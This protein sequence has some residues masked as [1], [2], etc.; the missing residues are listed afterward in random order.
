VDSPHQVSKNNISLFIV[1]ND[2]SDDATADISLTSDLTGN[3]AYPGQRVTFLCHVVANREILI[4]WTS[5]QYIG[6]KGADL[7]LLSTSEDG[8]TMR[9]RQ[10]RDTVATLLH[11]TRSNE[12]VTVTVEA[13][14][15]LTASA[16]YRN[17]HVS[18]RANGG[19]PRRVTFFTSLLPPR[20]PGNTGMLI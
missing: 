14:L 1:I 16:M 19:P 15:K 4:T 13:E 6:T 2:F 9:S 17:S 10:N 18:C 8:H 12:T 20:C 3:V 5:P 11:T 7:Q